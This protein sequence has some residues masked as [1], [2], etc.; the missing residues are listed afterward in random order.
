M[1]C[2]GSKRHRLKLIVKPDLS[3]ASLHVINA[4]EITPYYSMMYP[5]KVTGFVRIPSSPAGLTV[6]LV[7]MEYIRD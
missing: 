4:S 5:F 1:L 7:V 3:D 6:Y 2:E